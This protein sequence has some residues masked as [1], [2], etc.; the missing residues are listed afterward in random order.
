[1][2]N[3]FKTAGIQQLDHI[4][5]VDAANTVTQGRRQFEQVAPIPMLVDPRRAQLLALFDLSDMRGQD[6][7][8]QIAGLHA[9]RFPK[10]PK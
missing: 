9:A 6:L 4:L 10:V 7:L 5:K 1:M 8:L 3:E 2:S